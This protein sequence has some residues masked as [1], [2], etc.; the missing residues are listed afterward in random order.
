[1]VPQKGRHQGTLKLNFPFRV[2][3]QIQSSSK[4]RNSRSMGKESRKLWLLKTS[5]RFLKKSQ[6]TR[7]V[8]HRL[9]LSMSE[10]RQNSLTLNC[11]CKLQR[12]PATHLVRHQRR[13]TTWL[14]SRS[15]S[16]TKSPLKSLTRTPYHRQR[17]RDPLTT[18]LPSSIITFK[19]DCP[20]L[21]YS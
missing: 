13:T 20:K 14:K 19:K 3:Q 18:I 12:A 21:P 15:T 8:D 6:L 9:S 7:V 16:N 1:M 11:Y 17:H 2:R 10:K 4:K 5:P